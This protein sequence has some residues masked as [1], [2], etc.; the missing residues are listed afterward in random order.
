MAQELVLR[1]N[2]SFLRKGSDCIVTR[3]TFIREH[4]G[5]ARRAVV[6]RPAEGLEPDQR[7]R[8]PLVVVADVDAEAD[9]RPSPLPS[10]A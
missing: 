6:A 7:R 3:G 5:D 1:S 10:A 9:F 8:P 2:S 4:D